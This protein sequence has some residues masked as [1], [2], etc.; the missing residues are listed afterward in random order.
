[1]IHLFPEDF[2]Y[3]G[4]SDGFTDPF[5]YAPH[6]AVQEA[7]QI[8]TGMIDSDL[9]LSEAFSEGKMLGVLVCRSSVISSERPSVISSERS[10]SRDLLS[11]ATH[12]DRQKLPYMKQQQP[13]M[14]VSEAY[15]E[16]SFIRDC[17]CEILVVILYVSN[18]VR[19][20]SN[21]L[22]PEISLYL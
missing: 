19:Q 3:E 2:S 15:C 21:L 1:M 13:R 17:C 16:A 12:K 10:E 14:N 18:D 20:A 5:R 22:L 11:L 4:P 9:S 6:P 7:A 8:V